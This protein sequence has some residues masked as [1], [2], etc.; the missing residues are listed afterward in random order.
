MSVPSPHAV[1]ELLKQLGAEPGADH[2]VLER[3]LPLVYGELRRQAARYLRKERAGDALQPTALVREAYQQLIDRRDVHWQHRAHFFGIAAQ[4][5]R[6]ILVDHARGRAHARRGVAG[7]RVNAAFIADQPSIDLLDLDAALDRLAALDPQQSR[8]VE[9]R[10]FGGLS[11]EDT[12]DVLGISA[13]RAKRE[14][15]MARAWLHAELKGT[16]G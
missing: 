4:A 8:V 9:L 15:T 10:Y 5:M 2:A 11:N 12:A 3:L 7:R 16:R 1:T 6:R 13:T 14:W